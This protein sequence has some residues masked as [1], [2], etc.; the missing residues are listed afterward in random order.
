[1]RESK[2]SS[3]PL[4]RRRRRQMHIPCLHPLPGISPALFP[5]NLPGEIWLPPSVLRLSVSQSARKLTAN[6]AERHQIACLGG[7][8]SGVKT[9]SCTPELDI[10]FFGLG[11]CENNGR[12][13]E[14]KAKD[15]VDQVQKCVRQDF[16]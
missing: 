10:D 14:G 12:V 3:Q 16:L 1:M 4:P 7:R 6:E 9:A 5:P 2:E 8:E 11:E 13:G 15:C